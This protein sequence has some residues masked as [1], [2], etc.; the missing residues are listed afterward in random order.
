MS[1]NQPVLT[2]RGRVMEVGVWPPRVVISHAVGDDP[3][4]EQHSSFVVD[5]A[6]VKAFGPLIGLNV[7]LVV[8]AEWTAD[9]I[10]EVSTP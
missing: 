6:T 3:I 8:T 7:M 4:C 10:T 5:D 2:I 1:T 9:T